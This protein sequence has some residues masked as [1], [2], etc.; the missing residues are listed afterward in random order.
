VDRAKNN[1]VNQES[2]LR[3]GQMWLLSWLCKTYRGCNMLIKLCKRG[4]M[5]TIG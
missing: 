5:Q 1:L 4:I 2:S 3:Y